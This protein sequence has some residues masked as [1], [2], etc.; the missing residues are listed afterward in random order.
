[1]STPKVT[2]QAVVDYLCSRAR[3]ATL[4]AKQPHRQSG[5]NQYYFI[6]K[7]RMKK[8]LVSRITPF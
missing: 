8:E 5:P 4:E 2:S 6:W 1:M 7:A 3:A